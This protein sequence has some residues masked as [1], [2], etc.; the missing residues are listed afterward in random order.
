MNYGVFTL[1]IIS[2]ILASCGGEQKVSDSDPLSKRILGK[3][4]V[5]EARVGTDV[6]KP[7]LWMD[8]Q[9]D[10]LVNSGGTYSPNAEGTWEMNDSI[11]IMSMDADGRGENVWNWMV[12]ITGDTM[13]LERVFVNEDPAGLAAVKPVLKLART[14]E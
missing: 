14:K 12:Y 3:W 10:N 13:T 1:L 6:D 4:Q 9:K 8:F 7:D 2:V 11:G 5:V